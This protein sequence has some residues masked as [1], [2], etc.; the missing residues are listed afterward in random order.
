MKQLSSYIQFNSSVTA[1]SFS[2]CQHECIPTSPSVPFRKIYANV[3]KPS[4]I[5]SSLP[6]AVAESSDSNDETIVPSL[7]ACNVKDSN[8]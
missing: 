4:K 1:Y 6:L 2:L 3:V 8:V 7:T 5:D